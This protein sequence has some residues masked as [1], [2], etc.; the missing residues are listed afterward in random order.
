MGKL[1]PRY[2]AGEYVEQT[3]HFVPSYTTEIG[4]AEIFL[5][6]D[7]LSS[8]SRRDIE[9]THQFALV[10]VNKTIVRKKRRSLTYWDMQAA[11]ESIYGS[12][13]CTFLV[14]RLLAMELLEKRYHDIDWEELTKKFINSH[15]FH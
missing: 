14:T 2:R 4:D 3:W 8:D 9:L 6:V 12:G 11:C 15:R 7:R 5:Y 10:L 1:V 13:N